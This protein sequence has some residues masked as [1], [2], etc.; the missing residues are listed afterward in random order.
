MFE[1]SPD[2]IKRTVQMVHDEEHRNFD[3]DIFDVLLVIL[4]EQREEDDFA[5]VLDI[6]TESFQNSLERAEFSSVVRFFQKLEEL[7]SSYK[8]N[9]IWAMPH[10]EDFKLVISSMNMNS[11][12]E[13]F[14]INIYISLNHR[15]T[16]KNSY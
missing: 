6:I 14:W 1:L 3:A 7:E 13:G 11:V 8:T 9:Q 5:V 4:K 2:E 15:L 16:T 10:L 12:S